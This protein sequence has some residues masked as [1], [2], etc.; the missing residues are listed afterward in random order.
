MKVVIPIK[1]TASLNAEV[2]VDVDDVG[3]ADLDWSINE[4]DEF[5]VEAALQLR[6]AAG[7]GEIVVVTVGDRDSTEGLVSSMARGADRAVRVW[8]PSLEKADP[9]QVA[10][11]LASVVRRERPDLVLCG[12]RSADAGHSAT[13]VAMAALTGLPHVALV[14]AM[15]R[16]TPSSLVVSRQLEGHL[17]EQL[18]VHLP[19]LLTIQSGI[20]E[21]RYVPLHAMEAASRRAIEQLGLAELGLA[22]A[23]PAAH[24]VRGWSVPPRPDPGSVLPSEA[25]HAAAEI[26]R[27][28]A[29]ARGQNVA[30][31]A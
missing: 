29:R 21:P 15:S 28:L 19:A 26:L 5:S 22:D 18:R 10:R 13:G 25:D 14:S 8:D 16:E 6:D 11:V 24:A 31:P 20:N 4:W 23:G 3:E 30:D 1:H 17:R 7:C 27:L 2:L 9:I 12:A